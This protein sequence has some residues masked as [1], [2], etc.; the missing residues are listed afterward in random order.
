MEVDQAVDSL[1][2]FLTGGSSN[3]SSSASLGGA[4]SSH[5]S[6]GL[7]PIVDEFPIPAL[8]IDNVLP[9]CG[10]GEATLSTSGNLVTF[11]PPGGTAGTPV[12]ILAGESKVVAGSDVNKAIR[13]Y[14]EAGLEIA[15]PPGGLTLLFPANGV[16]G[17]ADVNNV[18]RAAGVTTYRGAALVAPGPNG[19]IDLRLWLPPVVGAQAVYSIATEVPVAGAIQTIANELTAPT[20]VVW[21]TPTIEGTAL[22]I[23]GISGSGGWIGL[24]IRRVFPVGIVAARENVQLATKF[25]GA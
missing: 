2:L 4:R 13:L 17:H 6:L 9:A 16:L 20:G 15:R 3:T 12:A 7:S 8:R 5:K 10:E 18:Q 25:K 14:R 11:T 22:V 24:W 21:V 1:S 23:P 19:V